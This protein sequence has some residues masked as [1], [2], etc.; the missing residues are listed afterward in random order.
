MKRLMIAALLLFTLLFV[1]PLVAMAK[2]DD[3]GSVVKLIERFYNVKHKGLPFLARA[4]LKTATTVARLSGGER[5]RL[6]EAG[7]VKLAYF[8]N[9]DFATGSPLEFRSSLSKSLERSWSPLIQ[10]LAPDNSEHTYIY[11]RNA[12]DKF[13]VLVLTLEKHD[14]TVVQITL[15]PK[16]LALL[17]RDP[18]GMGKAITDE[19]TID[20]Q[21]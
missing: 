15:S 19:A 6:A 12:G 4:G 9:Q 1:T 13:H 21:E 20:D 18:E 8:E 5:K 17:L 16:N 3:F 11:L 14:A 10:V 2:N 7:S